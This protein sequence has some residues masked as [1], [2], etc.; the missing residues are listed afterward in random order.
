MINI[1]NAALNVFK[2]DNE[3]TQQRQGL[4]DICKFVLLKQAIFYNKNME[5]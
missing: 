2:V 4:L 5:P 1:I 3:K